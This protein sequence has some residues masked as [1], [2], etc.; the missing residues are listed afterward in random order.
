MLNRKDLEEYIGLVG[1]AEKK[2]STEVKLPVANARRIAD[3]LAFLLL[4]LEETRKTLANAEQ[5][6]QDNAIV[7]VELDGG[8]FK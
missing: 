3:G 1:L 4:E 8:N 6:L 5:K 7:S 2:K